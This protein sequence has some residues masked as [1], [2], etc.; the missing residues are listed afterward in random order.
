VALAASLASLASLA[1]AAPTGAIAEFGIPTLNSGPYGVAPGPDGSTW[2]TEIKAD[3]IGHITA[4]GEVSDFPIPSANAKPTSIVTGPDGNL[5][6]TESN[7]NKIGRITPAGAI[8]EFDVPTAKSGPFRITAGPDGNLWFVEENAN[9]IGRITT[10]GAFAEFT[11]PTANSAPFG[12]APGSDGNL[13]FTEAAASANRIGRISPSGTFAEF[14]VPTAKSLLEAIVPGPD[15]NLWFTEFE[16]NNI[17]RITPAGEVTEFPVPTK[18]GGP[19]QITAA[20]DGNL[21]FTEH[22]ANKVALITPSG[23]ITEF[24]VPTAGAAPSGIAPGADGNLW[25]GESGLSRIGRV[26]AGAVEA[27][28]SA[29]VVSGGGQQGS[30]QTC[31]ASWATWASIA[32]STTLFGFDGYRWLLDGAAVASGQTYTPVVANV[33]HKLACSATVTYPIPLFVSAVA[34]S[35]PVTVS[36]P[37]KPVLSAVRESAKRWRRGGKLARASRARR[38]HLGTTFSFEL[39]VPASVTF[40]FTQGRPGRRVGH[41]CVVKNRRNARHRAC[42]RS[43]TVARLTVSAHA[44]S[45][46]VLFQGRVSKSR[47]LALGSYHAVLVATNAVGVRS[48]AASLRFE[49]VR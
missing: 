46:K 48:R 7:A 1:S 26:G 6:F 42:T 12:I 17:G 29:P 47:R 35:A 43:V 5:W 14:P 3:K 22:D 28:A 13:W 24:D 34:T 21:W 8:T 4:G 11:I 45:N 40:S 20:A 33:G 41:A 18:E 37:P 44:G 36:A 16:G 31:N 49:I 10:A 32:P 39:N 38:A 23:A 15:G 27:L 25:F 9:K 30:V 19:E 2:F